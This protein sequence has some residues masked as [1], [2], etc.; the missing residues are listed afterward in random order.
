MDLGIPMKVEIQSDSFG[1]LSLSHGY[2]QRKT[3]R[4]WERSQFLHDV[5]VFCR[6]WNPHSTPDLSRRQRQ[7]PASVVN[8]EE[9]AKAE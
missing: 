3:V 2:L 1:D 5:L 4:M 6:P 7:L 8:I 9:D